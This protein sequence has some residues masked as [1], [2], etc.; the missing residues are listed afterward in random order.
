MVDTHN[1]SSVKIYFCD[2]IKPTKFFKVMLPNSAVK[3]NFIDSG[4]MTTIG[5]N[6]LFLKWQNDNLWNDWSSYKVLGS[7]F[8]WRNFQWQFEENITILVIREGITT[9]LRRSIHCFFS[10]RCIFTSFYCAFAPWVRVWKQTCRLLWH[11][12]MAA[13]WFWWIHFESELLLY[14]IAYTQWRMS[15]FIAC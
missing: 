5:T 10:L 7:H 13:P 11:F 6:Q 8:M 4:E 15:Q 14:F 2:I 3:L 9:E 12:W 1:Q